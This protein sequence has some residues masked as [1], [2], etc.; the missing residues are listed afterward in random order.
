MCRCSFCQNWGLTHYFH[1][2]TSEWLIIE[3]IWK[4]LEKES[5]KITPGWVNGKQKRGDFVAT[6]GVVPRPL[7]RQNLALSLQVIARGFARL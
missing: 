2:V 3:Y 1:T 7:V 6:A 4:L 5:F